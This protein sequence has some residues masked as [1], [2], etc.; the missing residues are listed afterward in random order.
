M[1]QKT[2]KE[3]EKSIKNRYDRERESEKVK[4]IGEKKRE[5]YGRDRKID[6]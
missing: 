1:I 6:R 4:V 3:M 2:K 5:G